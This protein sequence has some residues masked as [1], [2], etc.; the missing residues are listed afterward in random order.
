[1]A[2]D[3]SSRTPA[4]RKLSI[5]VYAGSFDPLH[6]GH[7]DVARRAARMFDHLIFAIFTGTGS[8]SPL[9][10]GPER[11]ALAQEALGDI[12]NLTVESYRELTVEFARRAGAT[13]I[14]K[15]VRTVADFEYELQQAHMNSALAPGIES[16]FLMTSP[17]YVFYSSS[18]IKQVALAGADVSGMVPAGVE[19]ALRQRREDRG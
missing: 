8:K 13:A 14:V 16:I 3:D 6:L 15:G 11:V 2:G 18:L 7:R 10:A 4:G 17:Q 1:M 9:F 12:P 5:A 19:R